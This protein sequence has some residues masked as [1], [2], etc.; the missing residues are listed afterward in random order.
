M[1]MC[2]LPAVAN[3]STL[4]LCHTQ[5]PVA[6]TPYRSKK[7]N[8]ELSR[9]RSQPGSTRMPA[10]AMVHHAAHLNPPAQY[11][12]IVLSMMPGSNIVQTRV[13]C[14]ASHLTVSRAAMFVV[15]CDHVVMP[16]RW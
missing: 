9:G 11:N 15:T 3:F 14:G 7:L 4:L 6:W 8:Q 1:S 16:C 10:S 5:T 13:Y 12:A 2:T